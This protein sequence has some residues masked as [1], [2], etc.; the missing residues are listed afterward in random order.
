MAHISKR[1]LEDRPLTHNAL[2]DAIDQAEI[3]KKIMAG[4][5]RSLGG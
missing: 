3:F 1:F 5:G 2:Q 4:A